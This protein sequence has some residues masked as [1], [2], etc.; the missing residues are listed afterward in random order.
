MVEA[1]EA[2]SGTAVLQIRASGLSGIG[3]RHLKATGYRGMRPSGS[4]LGMAWRRR[5]DRQGDADRRAFG[6]VDL[7]DTLPWWVSMMRWTMARPR[8][9]PPRLV[10]FS[11][12]VK[13]R[14]C[15]SSVIPAP[16]SWSE[17]MMRGA[18]G[19]AARQDGGT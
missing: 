17:S 6:G 2:A 12:E 4:G 13:A 5:G 16:V 11:R 15:C 1:S 19:T 3:P 7:T 10:L 9:V 18:R 8:P 14:R